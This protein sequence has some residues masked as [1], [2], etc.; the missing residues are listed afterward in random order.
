M[1]EKIQ[2]KY[3]EKPQLQSG[4]INKP[5][6]KGS[7]VVLIGAKKPLGVRENFQKNPVVDFSKSLDEKTKKTIND[8]LKRQYLA[9]Q[10]DLDKT[11]KENGFIGK[12]WDWI[13]NTTGLGQGSDKTQKDL[14]ALKKQLD[15][16]EKHPENL[17]KAYKNITGKDLNAKELEKFKKGEITLK[18]KETVDSYKEGQKASVDVVAD[19]V[20]GVVSFG[21]YTV[22]AAGLVAAPFTGGSSLLI[23]AGAIAVAAG[24]GAAIKMGIKYADATSGG[25]EYD[26]AGYDA[27]TGGVNGLLAPITAGIGG[28]VGKTVATRLG[29]QVVKEG[30]EV[31]AEQ[32][33]KEVAVQT[34]QTGGKS[35]MEFGKKYTGGNLF[36]RGLTYT[37]ESA[38]IGAT[39][40]APDAYVRNGLTTGHWFDENAAEATGQGLMS[41]ALTGPLMDVG[42][43]V[44]GKFVQPLIKFGDKITSAYS[45]A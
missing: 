33:V 43:R 40:G 31:V 39:S 12:S 37:A 3:T 7:N 15:E 45:K 38:T 24:A 36:E 13:K 44:A 8:E 9:L 16:L 5:N 18:A 27:V 1:V 2:P 26:S 28:A 4:S 35:L 30:A 6:D 25:R 10:K 23:T 34:V 14:D 20:S 41:G 17:G 29:V 19:L 42:F 22:A 32:G 21:A 11:K